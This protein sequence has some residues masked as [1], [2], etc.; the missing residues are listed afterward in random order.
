MMKIVWTKFA[1]QDLFDI[2]KFHK[3]YS[4]KIFAD[5]IKNKILESPM[6]LKNYPDAGQTEQNSKLIGYACRYLVVSHCKILYL[7]EE[8]TIKIISVFDTRQ[9]PSKMLSKEE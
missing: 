9:D 1:K 3:D 6:F 7:V 4:G 2:Y 5:N 8:D